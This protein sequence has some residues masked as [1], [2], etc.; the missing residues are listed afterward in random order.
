MSP[1]PG[2][3]VEHLT[4]FDKPPYRKPSTP[5]PTSKESDTF[6]RLYVKGDCSIEEDVKDIFSEWL[7]ALHAL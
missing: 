2:T 3:P 5:C 1:H 7:Y 4:L 6:Y